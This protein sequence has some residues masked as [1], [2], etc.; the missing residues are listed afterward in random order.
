MSNVVKISEKRNEVHVLG[1][2][3]PFNMYVSA[4]A[5][6]HVAYTPGPF[7]PGV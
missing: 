1:L 6:V 3:V 4:W 2:P 5:L 7:A